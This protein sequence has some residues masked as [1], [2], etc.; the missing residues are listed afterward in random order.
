MKRWLAR[1]VNAGIREKQILI[2]LSPDAARAFQALQQPLAYAKGEKLFAEG[3][4]AAGLFV[5]VKGRARISI[6]DP[7]GRVV[8]SRKAA[9][10][11]VLGLS[12]AVSGQPHQMTAQALTPSHLGF[13]R[14]EDFVRFL[15]E[16]GDAAFR[17]VELLSRHVSEGHSR[18][19]RARARRV[20]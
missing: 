9:P 8:L 6:S 15:H 1:V 10:G 3:G 2:N 12:S 17:V 11:E 20:E 4:E 14:R 13:I 5:L 7:E 16:H 19:P 18:V